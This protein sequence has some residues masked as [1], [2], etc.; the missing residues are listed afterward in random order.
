MSKIAKISFAQVAYN[1][2]IKKQDRH[3]FLDKEVKAY[4]NAE[5]FNVFKVEDTAADMTLK[6]GV[7]LHRKLEDGSEERVHGL[8]FKG[9]FAIVVQNDLKFDDGYEAFLASMEEPKG[10]AFKAGIE[11]SIDNALIAQL[12]KRF[13]IIRNKAKTAE[14]LILNSN[15]LL[16]EKELKAYEAK[17]KGAVRHKKDDVALR[18]SVDHQFLL[19]LADGAVEITDIVVQKVTGLW[20]L[21]NPQSLK[22]QLKQIVKRIGRR[23]RALK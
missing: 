15:N 8:I 6:A 10:E 1:N 7:I 13:K 22:L 2:L 11:I 14:A 21:L 19:D 18:I 4:Y 5:S 9:G 20:M 17:L 12:N 16:T 3:E 23:A